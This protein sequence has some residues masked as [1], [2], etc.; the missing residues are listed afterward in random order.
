MARQAKC[1]LHL[2]RQGGQPHPAPAAA[3]PP[4]AMCLVPSRRAASAAVCYKCGTS[5]SVLAHHTE[6][7]LHLFMCRGSSHGR[8]QRLRRHRR[9][10]VLRETPNMTD[11]VSASG[12]PAFARIRH[13]QLR[14]AYPPPAALYLVNWRAA[15][16]AAGLSRRAHS[17]SNKFDAECGSSAQ[18]H[19]SAAC[20]AWAALPW[21]VPPVAA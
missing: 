4:A 14:R 20:A 15:S 9:C 18:F 11:G 13:S 21:A 8:L 12:R 19:H 3:Q 7:G 2:L 5:Q 17:A 6:G 1:D 10:I 16:D